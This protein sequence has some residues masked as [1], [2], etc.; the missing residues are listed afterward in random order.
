MT[1]RVLV[2]MDDNYSVTEAHEQ[3]TR[4]SCLSGLCCFTLVKRFI[5][6]QPA[7]KWEAH[8]NGSVLPFGDPCSAHQ[9]IRS[10]LLGGMHMD[11]YLSTSSLLKNL[12]NLSFFVSVARLIRCQVLCS[13][14]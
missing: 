3:S 13:L 11:V 14:A 10:A 5:S 12:G 2:L 1:S 6:L 9:A 4:P 8:D 7:V